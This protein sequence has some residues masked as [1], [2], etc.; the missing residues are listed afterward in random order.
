VSDGKGNWFVSDAQNHTIRRITSDGTVTTVAGKAGHI[1]YD[2][3]VGVRARFGFPRGLAMDQDGNLYVADYHFAGSD[4]PTTSVIR[5]I[6][7]TGNVTTVAGHGYDPDD[8][9]FWSDTQHRLGEAY[10]LACD[11]QGNVYVNHGFGDVAKLSVSGGLS[12]YIEGSDYIRTEALGG[13]NGRYPADSRS[14][15]RAIYTSAACTIPRLACSC[16]RG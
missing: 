6:S 7:P 9:S 5:R 12:A 3:G 8:A 1:G 13:F 4:N 11:K 14:G 2:D 16:R 10:G 15:R